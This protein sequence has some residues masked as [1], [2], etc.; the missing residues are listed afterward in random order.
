MNYL[1]PY[2]ALGG[3]NPFRACLILHIQDKFLIEINFAM[4][5]GYLS[6]V[7]A[8]GTFVLTFFGYIISVLASVSIEILQF[9]LHHKDFVE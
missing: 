3:R 9:E 8:I 6:Y 2:I 5:A 7:K 1:N 4:G